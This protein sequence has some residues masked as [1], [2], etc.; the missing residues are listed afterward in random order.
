MEYFSVTI[1]FY[2]SLRLEEYL[3]GLSFN[4]CWNLTHV[5][6]L[7]GTDTRSWTNCCLQPSNQTTSGYRKFDNFTKAWSFKSERYVIFQE[8]FCSIIV[9][10][11]ILTRIRTFPEIETIPSFHD[12]STALVLKITNCEGAN[13]NHF[14]FRLH[15]SIWRKWP[16]SIFQLTWLTWNPWNLGD[17]WAFRG[18]ETE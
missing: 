6:A 13:Y 3:T 2:C 11:S 14:R 15:Y 10:F 1:S 7:F 17:F 8:I 18:I 4:P 9:K 5:W 12:F 16:C